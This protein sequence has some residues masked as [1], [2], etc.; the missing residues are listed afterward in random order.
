MSNIKEENVLCIVYSH[1][2]VKN[3]KV[4][5]NFIANLLLHAIPGRITNDFKLTL[6]DKNLHIE[7]IGYST[8]GGLQETLYT[9]TYPILDIDTFNVE[10][11][12]GEVLIKVK[13]VDSKEM[14]FICNN[15]N[16]REVAL[17]MSRLVSDLKKL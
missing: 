12:E 7:A 8:W 3:S 17:A 6:T 9:E 15:E 2:E 1:K 16:Q 10:D 14:H 5:A 4:L 11:I 13:P